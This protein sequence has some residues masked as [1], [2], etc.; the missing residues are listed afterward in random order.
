MKRMITG[1][2]N[3]KADRRAGAVSFGVVVLCAALVVAVAVILGLAAGR[4]TAMEKAEADRIAARVEKL[5]KLREENEKTLHSYA[6]AD[7]DKG[8]VQIPIERAME[9]TVEALKKKEPKAAGPVG[10]ATPA[11]A[12]AA[13]GGQS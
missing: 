4:D 11:P 6:W 9:L 12:P 3:G 8:V 2:R 7:K 5:A 13:T 1:L 10:P